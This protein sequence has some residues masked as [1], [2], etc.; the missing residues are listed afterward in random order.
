[1]DQP[2]RTGGLAPAA[3]GNHPDHGHPV[4]AE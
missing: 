3:T 2:T 1:L 4:P